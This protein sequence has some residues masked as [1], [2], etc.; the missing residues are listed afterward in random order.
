MEEMLFGKCIEWLCDVDKSCISSVYSYD[1][2]SVHVRIYL[3]VW[4]DEEG[5]THVYVIR[6][7]TIDNGKNILLSQDY[8]NC[9]EI[10]DLVNII[11]DVVA[12]I[13]RVK[14]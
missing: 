3:A 7:F 6:V 4:N 11:P 12:V 1:E 8:E 9:V 2:Y 13:N 10:K 5:F 14:E